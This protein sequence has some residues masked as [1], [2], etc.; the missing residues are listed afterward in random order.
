[1]LK[2][3]SFGKLV[4]IATVMIAPLAVNAQNYGVSAAAATMTDPQ[5]MPSGEYQADSTHTSI[6]W[7]VN[8]LGL[9]DYT[10]RFTKFNAK[11]NFSPSTPHKSTIY[12]VIDPTSVETDYPKGSSSDISKV[13]FN[14]KL[15]FGKEWFNAIKFPQI[16]FKST[17]IEH[18]KEDMPDNTAWVYGDLTMLGVTRPVIMNVKFNGAYEKKP[19][20]KTAAIGF[21]GN[22]KIKRSDFGFSTYVPTIGDEVTIMIEAEFNKIG[23]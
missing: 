3:I 10:A 1:M 8:H 13:D 19:F 12:A 23:N 16:T 21:S 5:D 2:K 18:G 15:G 22:L 17:K 20:G 6:T 4:L 11:L 9:S 14:K 7:K